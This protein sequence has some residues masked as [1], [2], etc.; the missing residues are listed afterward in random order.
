M[1]R[2]LL[3]P[4]L[5]VTVATPPA[6]A[7]SETRVVPPMW[8]RADGMA[9]AL[10]PFHYDKVR[11]QHLIEGDRFCNQSALLLSVRYR[12]AG[13][14]S[15]PKPAVTI[16]NLT[17]SL[18]F[19][20]NSAPSMSANFASNIAGALTTVFSGSYNLP[21]QLATPPVETF[22][23]ECKFDRPF[24]YTRNQGNLLIE[25]L[26][27]GKATFQ[28]DYPLLDGAA[29]GIPQANW[30][31]AGSF[32]DNSR[33]S[34][35]LNNVTNVVPGGS[36]EPINAELTQ[37]YPTVHIYG[38]SSDTYGP[39][40]LPFDLTPFGAPGNSLYVSLDLLVPITPYASG[41]KFTAISKLP[42]PNSSGLSGSTIFMSSLHLDLTANALGIVCAPALATSVDFLTNSGMNLVYA[43]DTAQPTGRFIHQGSNGGP[44]IQLVGFFN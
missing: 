19:T 40:P 39:V 27:P 10:F 6:A 11:A 21:A 20:M 31:T 7:Q 41:S 38:F 35:Y 44:V 9:H 14:L 18:G 30:G 23:I 34:I 1:D 26:V 15:G 8:A 3:L 17:I 2:R 32:G 33:P 22:N 5:L 25:H 28:L 13:P 4:L 42:I 12:I 16:P 29:A 36:V 43:G 24:L 37:A